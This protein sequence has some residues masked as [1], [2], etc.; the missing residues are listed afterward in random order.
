MDEADVEHAAAKSLIAQNWRTHPRATI[1][2]T[3]R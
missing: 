1:T 2:T 3:R